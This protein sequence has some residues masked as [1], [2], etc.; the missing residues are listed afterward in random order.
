MGFLESVCNA[1]VNNQVKKKKPYV[2]VE[3]VEK[4]Q[5]G[6]F[7]EFLLD[8]N[9][10]TDGSKSKVFFW[11]ENGENL[12]INFC[13]G[14]AAFDKDSC[15]YPLTFSDFFTKKTCLYAANATEIFDF[16]TFLPK[17][18]G[19]NSAL[20]PNPFAKWDKVVIPYVS[21]DF[22]VGAGDLPYTGKKGEH[23]TMHFHGY[24]NFLDI[25]ELVKKVYPNPKR[26]L[27]TG[28]SAGSFGASALAGKI[29]DLYPECENI[30]VYC[31]SS[32]LKKPD[33]NHVAKEIW[34][35][36]EEIAEA[37]QTDDMGGDWL[38]NLGKKYGSRM[39]L[40]Y[41]CSTED[42]VLATYTR[43]MKTREFKAD[44][45]D[46]NIVREG[47]LN[48]IKR[49]KREGV[50]IHYFCNALSAGKLGGTVHCISQSEIWHEHKVEGISAAEWVADAV[51][52]KLY[53]VGL[54]LL[55]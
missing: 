32:Y 17:D 37:V 6:I 27:I 9:I 49:L 12:I 25:M 24:L 44:Q 14:G 15:K 47:F 26:L 22:H 28:N 33:W 38:L 23:K 3:S 18:N 20:S 19:I 7:N 54:S 51:D 41:S 50:D 29:I 34:K 10:C 52:G 35:A 2:R 36:P 31:D 46:I 39:K 11:K 30:T 13:G 5:S 42:I 48:R 1:Y 53:D 16:A 40:I 21:A 45:S 8:G 55:G 4:L 43:Y